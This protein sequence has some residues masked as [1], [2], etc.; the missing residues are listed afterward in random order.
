MVKRLRAGVFL[1]VAV[2]TLGIVTAPMASAGVLNGVFHSPYGFDE[3]YGTQP[4]ERAPRDPMAGQSV[5]LKTTTWPVSTGQTV[6]ITWTK[7]GVAQTPIGAAWDYNSGNNTY[8]T[9]NMGS[10]VRGDQITYTVRANVDGGGEQTV[11]PFSFAVTSWSGPSN[12][13]GFT[14]N[15]TSVDVTTGDTAGSFTPK[16]RFAFP[17]VDRFRTQIAPSGSGLNITGSSSYTVTDSASTLTLATTGLQVKIQK[18]PYRVAV[19]KV[20]GT[21]LIARQYD[22]ATF[23][24]VGWASD[25]ATTVTKIEDHWYSPSGERFE[26][27]GERYDYLD[28]RGKDVHNYVYN[29]YQDQGANHR[30]YLSVPFFTNS[31]GYGVYLPSTRYSIFNL[32]THLSD[33][34]GFTV[35]TSGALNSTADYYFYT[36]S[37]A[38]IL[39]DYTATTAR[40]EL[41]P[42]WAFG[43]WMSANEW[44]TQAEVM[45]ELGNVTSNNIPHSAMV[46]E[47]WADE[48]TFY[49]WHGATYTP[50][51][52]GQALSYSDLTFPA[53]TAWSDPRAMVTAAH[54]QNIKV[55]LWQIPVLKQNFDT[56]PPT[57][58]QQHINDRDYAIAQ[59]YVLGDG[60]GGAY[61]VPTGQWFG[62]ST[63]P[64][65]TKTAAVNWWM[66]K[67]AYLFDD[68]GID[69]FKTDGS[70]AVFGR[71]VIAGDGRK[72]DE[73]HNAY[74]NSYTGVYD[75]YIES[76]T[77]GNGV[78]FSRAGTSG[79]QGNSIFWAGDQASTFGAF[80]EAVRAGISA[81]QSGVP[82]WSWDLAGFTGSFPSS[83]LY[84]RSTAMATFSPIMQYHSEKASPSPSEAR[85][86]WNV[87][88]RTGDTSVIP[89]FR[90]F[91]N[92]RMNLVPYLYTE[93]RN[94]SNTGL[95]LMQAMGIQ[96]GS[97]ATA[98]AQDQQYMFGRQLLVAPITAQGASSK[99][100]Y[101]PAG[102][103]YDFWNGGR[104][105]GPGTKTYFAGTDSIPVYA[106]AGAI[107][108][109]NLNANYQLGGNIG[110]SVTSYPNLVFRIYPSGTSS[111]DYFEDSANQTRTIT[112]TESF[113]SH[114]VTVSAPA[115]T[116]TSTLQVASTK[117]TSV[118]RG[119]TTLTEQ[120][121]V[122][123]LSSASEGWYWDPVQQLTFVKLP[124][125]ASARS[126]VL[127]GVDKAA[128][129]AE[130]GTNTNVTNNT[131][132]PGYTGTG[133]VDGFTASGDSVSV[134]VNSVSGS[135]NLKFRY[136]NGSGATATRTV[137]VD[138]VSVG[139]VSLPATGNWDT[140]ATATLTTTLTAGKHA[141]RLSYDS[142]NTGAINL[143]NVTVARP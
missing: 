78:Q 44:N 89:T 48:A 99:N 45:S 127:N 33:M 31:A 75:T 2:L 25:G 92:V 28:Q 87:Q 71:N 108:P 129:E 137:Y 43:L 112:S 73:L 125:S 22:P 40:P 56:N 143:D 104:A 60:A 66:S 13:T 50:K 34:A 14:N 93:A 140:W 53:G 65:F 62:D 106:K 117:P 64:D 120:A 113:S 85:T 41:P 119:G 133:F 116:T 61:R 23:R 96:Y 141:I 123:A 57:A 37:R 12:V 111:Y 79:A 30:T 122:A 21:T 15:G 36:G 9:L 54:N 74:P 97:D 88:A 10:F 27:F 59:G 109:L 69:G 80:Q 132:H 138:G 72:G 16:I 6:W 110:N 86:P 94:S 84:L 68:V 4:T 131:D 118:T 100:V 67:R 124:S 5:V 3:L 52:G 38:E 26:G 95:P 51:P 115:L 76:K 7:N 136:A 17:A 130:F 103:W 55:V 19:Y 47:Q 135:H 91:A 77:G 90:K 142:G 128:Y 126:V 70:E 1:A 101:L 121:S 102:E 82:F 35:D 20:D 107:V 63:V 49:L 24:N 139:T 46:L 114:T 8:W 32:G 81:G 11:G 105:Q 18:S 39:D 58:P 83:E 98:A 42:K 29:Q 134:D